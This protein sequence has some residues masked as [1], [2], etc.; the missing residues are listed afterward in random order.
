[1]SKLFSIY[2]SKAAAYMNPFI[3]PT[4]PAAMRS[5]GVV[6]SDPNSEFHKHAEDYTLFELGDWDETL[7]KLI[8]LSTPHAVCKAIEL[9]NVHSNYYF[10]SRDKVANG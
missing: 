4:V 3:Q 2:D 1:M 6:C 10:A 7:G 8:P 5:F 9:S